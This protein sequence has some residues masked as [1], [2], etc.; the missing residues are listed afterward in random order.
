MMRGRLCFAV[1]FLAVCGNEGEVCSDHFVIQP[2]VGSRGTSSRDNSGKVAC[3]ESS[4]TILDCI[5]D[6]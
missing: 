5:F 3:F 4:S 1:L 6:L 2:I